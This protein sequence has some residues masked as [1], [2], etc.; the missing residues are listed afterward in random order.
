VPV[1]PRNFENY[2][3]DDF[4]VSVA[5]ITV[6]LTL[7]ILSL[8]LAVGLN[9]FLWRPE[10]LAYNG[11]AKAF[12]SSDGVGYAI[13]CGGLGPEYIDFMRHPW[14][15]YI[16]RFLLLFA[17]LN[18]GVGIFNLMPFPPLDVFHL[19]ND[20]LLKGKLT[21]NAQTFQ[22]AHIILMVLCFTGALGG[23]LNFLTGAVEDAVLNLLLM[24]TGHA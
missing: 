19:L 4:L 18:L 13:L 24:L 22:I 8:S 6:N 15:Q 21:L 1:N 16:Q 17:Y 2:R 12:L 7:F 9:S 10:V 20:I 5:G 11:G 14:V 23:I 3:R